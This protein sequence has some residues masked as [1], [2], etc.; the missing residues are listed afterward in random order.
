MSERGTIVVS[1][2]HGRADKLRQ[3][4]DWYG[5]DTHYVINGDAINRGRDSCET[6]N[7]ICDLNA[8]LVLGNHEYVT[9]AAINDR[10]SERRWVWLTMWLG[11]RP[12]DKANYEDNLLDSYGE[13]RRSNGIETAFYFKNKLKTLGHLAL[14]ENAKLY[15]QDDDLLVVHAGVSSQ[16]PWAR[17]QRKLDETAALARNGIF[18]EEPSQLVSY[19]FAKDR[20]RPADIGQTLITGHHH[21]R[22]TNSAD[23]VFPSAD[24]KPA[25]VLLA[26]NLKE[27]DP[28]FAYESDTGQIRP[29]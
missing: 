26:S 19:H 2:I 11:S 17:Q 9:L 18:S 1:D 7:I 28:L 22:S 21:E 8:D 13:P 23:R 6:L 25:R 24:A 5:P 29:F 12:M 20:Y 4:V 27:G 3:V 14:L 16:I 15:Y 10:D